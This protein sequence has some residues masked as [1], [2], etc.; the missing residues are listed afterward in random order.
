MEPVYE[1][2]MRS[3]ASIVGSRWPS[4]FGGVRGVVG[5]GCVCRA[6]S[7]AAF[8]SR[9]SAIFRTR[10]LRTCERVV[11]KLPTVMGVVWSFQTQFRTSSACGLKPAHSFLASE[12]GTS[13]ARPRFRLP[14]SQLEIRLNAIK[15]RMKAIA[16]QKYFWY[17]MMKSTTVLPKISARPVICRPNS[18]QDLPRARIVW[19]KK[20]VMA[21]MVSTTVTRI[22][23]LG[24]ARRNKVF[25]S[26]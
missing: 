5:S 3:Y 22:N 24:S 14:L 23:S 18:S 11:C 1:A 9:A 15:T 7:S 12:I 19:T 17:C 8:C 25:P 2:S 10:P 6:C 4:P 21:E 26:K 13:A 16:H 20:S